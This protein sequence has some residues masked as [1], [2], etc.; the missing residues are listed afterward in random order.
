V[1]ATFVTPAGV[2]YVDLSTRGAV[3]EATAAVPE[4]ALRDIPEPISDADAPGFAGGEPM[5]RFGIQGST[6]ELLAVYAIVNSVVVNFPAVQRVQ[7]L[8]DGE[9][10]STLAGHVDLSHPL[11]AD[12]TLLAAFGTEARA[13][14]ETGPI[15]GPPAAEGAGPRQPPVVDEGEGVSDE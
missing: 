13:Q 4:G 2:A 12:T 14:D 9:T 1:R 7:I 5:P 8:L 15:T 10:A 3:T 11:S 6:E